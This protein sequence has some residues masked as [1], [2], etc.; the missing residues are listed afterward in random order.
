M[1]GRVG[2]AAALERRDRIAVAQ[3]ARERVD[4]RPELRLVD[5]IKSIPQRGGP[6]L[7]LLRRHAG[8][9]RRPRASP[10]SRSPSPPRPPG[11]PAAASA[12]PA[13]G[14]AAPR[15]WCSA[16]TVRPTTALPA[17][18]RR[19]DHPQRRVGQRQRPDDARRPSSA[20]VNAGA[21][22]PATER[23]RSS[24]TE[25]SSRSAR[26]GSKIRRT[27]RSPG[28]CSRAASPHCRLARSSLVTAITARA[29]STCNIGEHARR[30]RVG[31]D[32]RDPQRP[33]D[34][35]PDRAVVVLDPHARH[36]QRVQPR[37]D[38]R[39]RLAEPADDH[40]VLA[41]PREAPERVVDPRPH[42]QVGDERQHAR[43]QDRRDRHQPDVIQLQPVARA[44]E[45]DVAV[46]DGR[47]RRRRE[48][49]GVD[50]VEV[51]ATARTRR[52]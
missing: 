47:H 8:D 32:D 36:A 25:R 30:P 13:P 2:R 23:V 20:A 44:R 7:P 50:E 4:Q 34:R 9:R 26:C 12:R 27:T 1:A 33:R 6:R 28:E 46:A 17:G 41:R 16:P 49:H 42:E 15:S 31:E 21:A 10:R 18:D 38:R 19:L 14:P 52:C 51:R 5:I 35:D 11:P 37:D 24:S 43:Q 39:A 45:V 48:V 40:V 3:L 29:R 22:S